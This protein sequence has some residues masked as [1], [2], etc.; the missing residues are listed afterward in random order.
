MN[1]FSKI[2]LHLKE[3]LEA[4]QRTHG[5]RGQVLEVDS[6]GED[7]AFKMLKMCEGLA[8]DE[9]GL[10]KVVETSDSA[11]NGES[12]SALEQARLKVARNCS[13]LRTW[14]LGMQRTA[15]IKSFE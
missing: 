14:Q 7:Q 10:L 11:L 4:A 9:G 15:T 5:K 2:T 8:L 3:T 1:L 12:K 6:Q 13:R